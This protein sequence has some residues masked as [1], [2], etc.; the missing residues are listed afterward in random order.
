MKG[1]WLELWW[2]QA[3]EGAALNARQLTFE[4]VAA[5]QKSGSRHNMLHVPVLPLWAPKR[6]APPSRPRL[7]TATR[8]SRFPIPTVTA[9]ATWRVNGAVSKAAWWPWPF[10]LES[11]VRVTCD[12]GYLCANFSLP[13]HSVLNLGPMYATYRRQ[14]AS[15]L[16]ALARGGGIRTQHVI[17]E[18]AD[19]LVGLFP[20]ENF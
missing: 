19:K 15:S 8:S 5:S 9:A 3:W 11:G 14:T 2:C 12:V 20:K 18:K 1:N 17:Q 13:G 16:N 6:L 10:D 7:Q 4:T